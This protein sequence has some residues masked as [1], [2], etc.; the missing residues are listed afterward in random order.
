MLIAKIYFIFFKQVWTL[1]YMILHHSGYEMNKTD[2]VS[3]NLNLI[4]IAACGPTCQGKTFQKQLHWWNHCA[5]NG[6]SNTQRRQF[7]VPI[8]MS[9]SK[10]CPFFFYMFAIVNNSLYKK[11]RLSI[12]TSVQGPWCYKDIV[13]DMHSFF[14]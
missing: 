7:T 4:S 9:M 1:L 2:W 14:S 3:L 11:H 8:M 13:C 6:T 5:R 10:L 12:V